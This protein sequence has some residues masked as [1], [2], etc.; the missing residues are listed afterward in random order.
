MACLPSG[1]FS[2]CCQTLHAPGGLGSRLSISMPTAVFTFS[3]PAGSRYVRASQEPRLFV[4]LFNKLKEK[5]ILHFVSFNGRKQARLVALSSVTG[6]QR[7][8]LGND[9]IPLSALPTLIHGNDSVI[10][11][12]LPPYTQ[13]TS[14]TGLALGHE[15]KVCASTIPS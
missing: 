6:R 14:Q 5:C 11:L 1:F 15:L 3:L 7:A 12:R 8:N 2:Q 13:L 9:M 4:T 10:P